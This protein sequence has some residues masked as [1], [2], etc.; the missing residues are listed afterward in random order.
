LRSIDGGRD[1]ADSALL[2]VGRAANFERY[3]TAK[4][5]MVSELGGP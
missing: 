2:C 3:R 4:D 1:V 5:R